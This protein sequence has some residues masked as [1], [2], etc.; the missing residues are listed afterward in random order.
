[1]VAKATA[2]VLCGLPCRFPI[3][4]EDGQ[5]FCCPACR[6]VSAL[7]ANEPAAPASDEL[8]EMA[9]DWQSA[10][11]SLGGLWCPSCAWLIGEGLARLP[12]VQQADV[13]FIQRE[14]R[15]R[16][17]PTRTGLSKLTR[18]V[19]R[20]GYRA[21]TAGDKPHNE[22]EA[23]WNRL[24]ISGV[25]AM[26]VMVLSFML[27][28][29]EW[30]GRASPDTQWLAD[31][32]QL[33]ILVASVPVI[34][35]LGLPIL[36]AGLAS[37]LRGRPNTHTL[38]ALGAFSAFGLSLRNFLM[39]TGGIYFDTA[40]ILLF[41][42][43]LGRWFEM[44]AQ[45]VSGQA[46]ERLW[47][48]MP[49]E[50]IQLTPAGEV[51]L[52]VDEVPRGARILVRPG[53]RIPVDALVAL[54]EGDVDES[55][56]T[57]EPEPVARRAGDR[58]MAGTLNL[59]GAFQIVTTAVG[60]ETVVGQIGRLL[61]QARWQ[62]APVERLADKLAAFMVPTAVILSA[63]TFAYWSWYSGLETGLI[64]AL[65]VLLIACPCALG[66][67]TPL[68][69]WLG[70]GRATEAGLILRNTAVLER[71]DGVRHV[72][73]DK[74]GT[75]TLRPMR[76]QAIVAEDVAEEA[77]LAWVKAV[78]TPSEHPVGQAIV[79]GTERE[80]AGTASGLTTTHFRAL[81]GQGVTGKVQGTAVWIGSRHLMRDQN[82]TLS[83]HLLNITQT[84]QRQGLTVVYAGWNG[85]VTGL[86]GL[87]ETARAETK[88][89]LDRL[90]TMG[91][92]SSVLTGDDRFA[93][94][95]WQQ[96]LGVP[97]FAEQ[98]PE[99][100]VA[101]LSDMTGGAAMV[102]DGINDGPAL[103]AATVGLAFNQGTD[104]ACAAADVII[105]KDD[106]RVIP[107]LIDLSRATLR[108]VRQ[109]L[110]WSFFYNLIGLALAVNGR[111][112][113]ELAAL[114]MVASNLIVTSN[115]LRLRKGAL[116]ETRPANRDQLSPNGTHLVMTNSQFQ[117]Q[118]DYP[119]PKT[120]H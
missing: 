118:L 70:L 39:G 2:C 49:N 45:K 27:Y 52:P 71:L 57:G 33:M 107:W 65:S 93:G 51:R 5:V 30:T 21:W 88:E 109:N 9:A 25:A 94:I 104:V 75:I 106:L 38:I 16:F 78:E 72:F 77:F 115:A 68:T 69:L 83:P 14:A 53:E 29:R 66:I 41:L 110:A 100:K 24:L 112:Q 98:R 82:L 96:Q 56:L 80:L 92:N 89:T 28:L 42:V 12:G 55:L 81:P 90:Q 23:H 37:L 58:V 17:D 22:E 34:V 95:R 73:F 111:L 119:L 91:L 62:R 116:G 54:G 50:A 8:T 43:A 67:A 4:N 103:A 6:E 13:S 120:D 15:I 47:Q 99:D 7:L 60:S 59:D 11:L 32:F 79:S 87:G 97:V 3:T 61:H 35:I 10:T 114:F 31:F 19:K 76:L 85:R 64:H 48:Q 101:R 40:A 20:W 108:K 86:L 113:P 44:R 105:I 102:G 36:R 117:K 63:A 84:W 74:T 18:Q 46:V 1:M 26:H